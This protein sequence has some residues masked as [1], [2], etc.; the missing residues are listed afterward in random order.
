MYYVVVL[1]RNDENAEVAV[2]VATWTSM[3]SVRYTGH[4]RPRQDPV[5]CE[6]CR[7]KKLKC[8]RVHPCSNCLARD[9]PCQFGPSGRSSV[10]T[11]APTEAQSSSHQQDD[12]ASLRC[13]N[14]SIK[15]RLAR[16]EGVIESIVCTNDGSGRPSK[17]RRLDS[18][19][20]GGPAV[21]PTPLSTTPDAES[22][23]MFCRDAQWLAGVGR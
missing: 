6:S 2:R 13:E 21:M 22:A 8:S 4:A 19:P 17:S 12:L 20:G 3:N 16:L 18:M 11:A 15:E 23:R 10:L 1:T 7:K 5:S 9:I 14:A